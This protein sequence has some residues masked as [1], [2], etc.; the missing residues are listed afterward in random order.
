MAERITEPFLMVDGISEPGT[1]AGITELGAVVERITRCFQWL[2]V[3]PEP[4]SV[5]SG[6]K[7][8]M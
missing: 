8:T 2:G 3:I 6:N 7:R 1:D 5:G 4:G